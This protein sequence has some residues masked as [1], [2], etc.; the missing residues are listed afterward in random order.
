MSA[1]TEAPIVTALAASA[2]HG[3]SKRRK[4]PEDCV[5]LSPQ[6]AVSTGAA[7][8]VETLAAESGFNR[9]HYARGAD[10]SAYAVIAPSVHVQSI[11]WYVKV[12]SSN[13]LYLC[14]SGFLL[15]GM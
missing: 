14:R 15:L 4:H 1:I 6:Q 5:D 13:S 3:E 2:G 8:K 11:L 12:T 7:Q 9:T 10:Q